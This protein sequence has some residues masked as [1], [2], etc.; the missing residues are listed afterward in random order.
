M[1]KETE[2]KF[3]VHDRTALEA[4]RKLT[5]LGHFRIRDA[6]VEEVRDTY[7]DTADRRFM[8][9]GYACRMRQTDCE[10]FI[11]IKSLA[12]PEDGVAVREELETRI[13][14]PAMA[15][16]PETW[17]EGPAREL[18][19][20]IGRGVLL[21]A[22]CELRQT[23]WKR[24]VCRAGVPSEEAPRLFDISIDEVKLPEVYY[25]LEI[26][27]LPAAGADELTEICALFSKTVPMQKEKMSK[28]ERALAAAG[29]P[30]RQD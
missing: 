17:P 7:M 27:L 14:G 25:C 29:I 21:G 4:A 20:R 23:R 11:T 13:D 2:A 28:F 8:L 5:S 22:L 18:A 30:F 6:G 3:N 15:V 9:S 16:R 1:S 12:A 19:T 24:T 10:Y 26:E